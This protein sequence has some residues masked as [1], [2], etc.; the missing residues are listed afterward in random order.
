MEL[1][2]I[3]VGLSGFASSFGVFMWL[4][5]RSTRTPS[6]N[7]A[8]TPKETPSLG[9]G[10]A[11]RNHEALFDWVALRDDWLVLD[12]VT[13]GDKAK[14]EIIE[15]AIIDA[16]GRTLLDQLVTPKAHSPKSNDNGL[17]IGPPML[18]STPT[19]PQIV[20]TVAALVKDRPVIAYDVELDMQVLRRTCENW[21]IA[22]IA[23]DRHCAM[24]AYASHRG[25]AD[26]ARRGEYLQHTLADAVAHEGI[27][28][29]QDQRALSGAR[30]TR[31]LIVEIASRRRMMEA[32]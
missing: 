1:D 3:A 17:Q 30:I 16:Y 31:D 26:P 4:S 28:P 20:E 11:R 29:P 13:T 32:A 15:I 27:A 22:P 18:K 5:R 6:S 9:G 12:L 21:S 2:V 25:I 23:V 24:L 19:W 7:I 8:V 14:S 10:E